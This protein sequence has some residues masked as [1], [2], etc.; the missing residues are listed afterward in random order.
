M[1]IETEWEACNL[2][3][4][5][6]EYEDALPDGAWPNWVLGNHDRA[7]VASRVGATKARAAALMLLTLRGTP[8]IYQGE[9]LGMENVP[10]PHDRLQDPWEKNV[11]GHGLGR[12]PVRT[13]IAWEDA[14]HGG[15]STAEPWL[16]M[17]L[18][19]ER[20]VARQSADPGSMLAFYRRLLALRRAH[21]V[22]RQGAL[23]DVRAEPGVLRYSRTLGDAVAHVAINWSDSPAEVT[24]PGTPVLATDGC[25]DGAL[26]PGTGR[27]SLG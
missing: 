6:R 17:D 4:L 25:E 27:L 12:D 20:I 22:L 11:P 21:A 10:I 13:P 19:P 3:A 7:R 15:F 24:L 8:T 9:E 5:I 26:A 14:P 1:L 23:A 16:P 18:A 2:A